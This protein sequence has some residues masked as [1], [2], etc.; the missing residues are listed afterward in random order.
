[1]TVSY[2]KFVG[3]L[4]KGI[5]GLILAYDMDKA[6]GRCVLYLKTTN[7]KIFIEKAVIQQAQ[8]E[9]ISILRAKIVEGLG[10]IA[11]LTLKLQDDSLIL[12]DGN[13]DVKSSTRV[14]TQ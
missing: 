5:K 10:D 9:A 3:E 4:S 13:P 12:E 11:V 6:N 1:M 14:R 7:Q 8:A 2:G